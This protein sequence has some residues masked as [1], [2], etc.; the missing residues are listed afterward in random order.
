MAFIAGVTF[1]ASL[2]QTIDYRERTIALHFNRLLIPH[3]ATFVK[4]YLHAKVFFF[5]LTACIL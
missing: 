3:S 2:A 5:S 1:I 4:I